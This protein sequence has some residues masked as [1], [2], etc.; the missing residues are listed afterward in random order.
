V[1]ILTV[2]RQCE[3]RCAYCRTAQD[4]WPT[5]NQ[6]DCE[7]AL[8]IYIQNFGGGD[9]KLFGGEPLLAGEATRATIEAAQRAPEIHRVYLSTNGIALT[10]DWLDLLARTPKLVLT[11]SLDGRPVDHD[12]FRRQK[13]QP[14]GSFERA[15]AMLHHLVRAP[16][17]V[18]TQTIAPQTASRADE[19]LAYLV[20]LGFRRFN[21]LPVYFQP[22][23]PTELLALNAAFGRIE[24]LI[25]RRWERGER[26]YLRNLYTWAPS[27][28]FNRG[29]VVDA[30]RRIH[31]SNAGLWEGLEELADKTCVGDLDH[32]PTPQAV[33]EASA[34]VDGWIKQAVA[35][36][37][38]QSTRAV[39]QELTRLCRRLYPAMI[40]HRLRSRG[41]A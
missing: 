3:L 41:A 33:C 26:F 30:D 34:Q 13:G 40:K 39:D 11:V 35:P 4:G 20:D 24:Q 25:V 29:F 27:P 28:F 2:T 21:L 16:R 7:R 1:L 23:A 9:V 19:N 6:A 10:P 36:E 14:T 8:Q 31:P 18:I 38:W 5:L 12:R 15:T 37:L 22:W 17:V 32:P